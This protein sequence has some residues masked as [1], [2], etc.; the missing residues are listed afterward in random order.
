MGGFA[1]EAS[2]FCLQFTPGACQGEAAKANL[3]ATL[4][5]IGAAMAVV[6]A[7]LIIYGG[8]KMPG[9]RRGAWATVIPSW[10]GGRG[11]Q[12]WMWTF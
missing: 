4:L 7:P 2:S 12:G 10:A 6:G 5:V 3:G 1:L 11:G 9:H 8:Q